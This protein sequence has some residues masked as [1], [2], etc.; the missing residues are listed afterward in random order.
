MK[1][2]GKLVVISNPIGN[3]MYSVELNVKNPPFDQR[4]GP[5]GRFAYALPYQKI[6]DAAMFG[7]ANPLFGRT[8]Q[9]PSKDITWPAKSGYS[10]KHRQGQG[11]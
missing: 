3:G 1:K 11:R 9:T 2:D 10:D 5:P 4:E 6:M 8:V 7:L